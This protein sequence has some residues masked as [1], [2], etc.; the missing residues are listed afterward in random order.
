VTDLCWDIFFVGVTLWYLVLMWR[1]A[2]PD[3]WMAS[4]FILSVAG[5][6]LFMVSWNTFVGP[7]KTTQS[8]QF[9]VYVAV[10]AGYWFNKSIMFC[11]VWVRF[12][13]TAARS[14]RLLDE[15][16]NSRSR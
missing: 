13:L 11:I 9:L 14:M 15:R 3:R 7:M 6:I 16:P 1:A 8:G 4:Q 10:V 5:G 12:D 2:R